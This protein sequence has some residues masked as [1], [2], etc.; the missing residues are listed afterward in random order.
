MKTVSIN[1]GQQTQRPGQRG[2]QGEAKVSE[3]R[4]RM[5]LESGGASMEKLEQFGS[6]TPLGCPGQP[7]ELACIYVQLVRQRPGL[8][9]IR[10]RGT[11]VRS[12]HFGFGSGSPRPGSSRLPVRASSTA[13]ASAWATLTTSLW[14][15]VSSS[16]CAC[17][18]A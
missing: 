8:R 17:E 12:A 13:A 15:A 18:F 2:Q 16:R 9:I 7:V 14:K 10:R 11:S 5:L 3:A 1:P 6:H 4:S